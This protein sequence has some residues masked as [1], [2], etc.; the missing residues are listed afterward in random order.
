[1]RWGRT[2]AWSDVA[3]NLAVVALLSFA[4]SKA[5]AMNI[6]AG[7]RS[8]DSVDNRIAV[9]AQAPALA[10]PRTRGGGMQPK[11]PASRNVQVNR[12]PPVKPNARSDAVVH[13]D[14]VAAKVDANRKADVGGHPPAQPPVTGPGHPGPVPAA[15]PPV[16]VSGGWARP[17]W[18][19]WSPGGAIAADAALGFVSAA[20]ATWATPPRPGLCWYYTDPTEQDGFWD[21][22]P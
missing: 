19:R 2:M 17:G 20:I 14:G 8:A 13:R 3:R 5:D 11:R 1:M 21:D 10:G 16:P 18:Y 4:P 9:A 6:L 7:S 12:N 22:C 15:K